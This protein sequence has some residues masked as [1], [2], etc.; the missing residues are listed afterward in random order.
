M[1]D[2]QDSGGDEPR[3]TEQGTDGDLNGYHQQVKV[4]PGTFLSQPKQP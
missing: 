2:G 1:V 4:V 3:S